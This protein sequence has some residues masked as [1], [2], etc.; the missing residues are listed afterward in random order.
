MKDPDRP[1]H[2]RRLFIGGAWALVWA[3]V[4]AAALQ[5]AS[6]A[7]A[8]QDALM[9]S[10][11]RQIALGGTSPTDSL[12]P[13][14]RAAA[15]EAAL[16]RGTRAALARADSLVAQA[17]LRTA[18]EIP[19]PSLNLNYTR[20]LPHYHG[21]FTFP[22]DYPWVRNA[23]VSSAEAGYKSA[24]YRYVFERESARFEVD[25]M[26][27]RAV[28]AAAH[29]RA[30]RRNAI[31]A[32]SLRQ[33]AVIRREA[34]D[35]SDMDVDLA[36][37][38]AGQQENAAAADSL[39]AVGALLD[40][41]AVVGL[42][43]DSPAVALVDSLTAPDSLAVQSLPS[44]PGSGPS[45][46]LTLR[47]AFAAPPSRSGTTPGDSTAH[48]R[49]SSSVPLQVAAAEAA[50]QSEES[51]LTL[52]H[53]MAF[54]Q[55]SFQA[56]LEGGDPTQPYLLPTVGFSIPFPL[57]NRAGGEI[58]LATANRNRAQAELEIARR[59]TVA[60]VAV[61]VREL[62]A[63]LARV[64]RDHGLLDEAER[65]VARSLTGFAEG[66]SALPAVMEAQRS[67]R[68]AMAQYVDDLAAANTAAAAVHLYTLTTTP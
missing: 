19:N 22:F 30:S 40:L 52:A 3:L 61:A 25:T 8:A 44:R 6:P 51:G 47:P 37:V 58:A 66:A 68:D 7:A 64:R 14:T 48:E 29:S 60:A 33:L 53:R 36:S 41:Q 50:L 49:R 21:I 11:T 13:L 20:D 38:Y 24:S 2:G 32:D 34:G 59:E 18:R 26:Y 28:A 45:T 1:A 27:T 10:A 35:A 63:A 9:A 62:R 43:A 4:W 55:P 15:E 17:T 42:R 5:I 54:A 67:A 57:F 12:V 65:V 23:R 46:G 31:D 56:G 39:A 16:A